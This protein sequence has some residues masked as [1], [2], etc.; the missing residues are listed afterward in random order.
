MAVTVAVS[1]GPSVTVV[2]AV[3]VG[4]VARTGTH[5]ARHGDQGQDE[6]GGEDD[7]APQAAIR[8]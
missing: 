3:A 6:Q 5:A 1:L 2:A 4:S 7:P 8:S